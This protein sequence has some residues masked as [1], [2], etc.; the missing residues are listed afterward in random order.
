VSVLSRLAR[1]RMLRGNPQPGNRNTGQPVKNT[2]IDRL[3]AHRLVEQI[4]DGT[5]DTRILLGDLRPSL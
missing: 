1:D 4:I 5:V 3:K 2:H